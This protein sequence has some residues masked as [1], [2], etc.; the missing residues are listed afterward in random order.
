MKLNEKHYLF[1]QVTLNTELTSPDVVSTVYN[2]GNAG[3][4]TFNGTYTTQENKIPD[5]SYLLSGGKW[6]H[7]TLNGGTVSKVQ[8]FRTWL[9]P[10]NGPSNVNVQFSIDGVIDGDTTNSIEGIENDIN[11]KANNKVYNMNGQL[12]R[13]GST[14]LEGL[15]KGVYIVN[16]KKYIVK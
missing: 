5:G 12:V 13:N 1:N 10:V 16:N 15:P 3:S 7:M 2:C 8:G 4:L 6:Y 11:S 14:S 9:E